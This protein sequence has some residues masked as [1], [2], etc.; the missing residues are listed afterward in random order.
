MKIHLF[1]S[2][3]FTGLAATSLTAQISERALGMS[4]GVQNALVLEVPSI[5]ASLLSDTWA[6]YM[7]DFY[8][9]KPKWQRRDKEWLSDD[10]DIAAIGRGNTVDVFAKTEAK[11]D[12]ALLY[13][14]MDL[15]GAYLNSREHPQRYAE[16]EK[17]L[18]R[19]GLE[20]AR[21]KLRVELD[22]EEKALK[23]L[24]RDLSKLQSDKDRSER[25]IERAKET[26]AKAELDIKQSLQ[27]QEQMAQR[28]K[29]QEE[30]IKALQQRINGL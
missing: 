10:A 27:E 25:E 11:G 13:V 24:N 20:A 4:A 29:D 7:K 16:A 1:F 22:E 5:D 21:A 2:L 3:L 6:T 19:F 15:G 9:A 12:G 28:I 8:R 23:N 17:I 18:L 30:A 26:I 14:W